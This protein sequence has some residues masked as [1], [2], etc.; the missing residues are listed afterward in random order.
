MILNT[1][2][3]CSSGSW[4]IEHL[5]PVTGESLPKA[6]C[7]NILPGHNAGN[8]PGFVWSLRGV[9]SYVRYVHRDER[10]QLTPLQ[11]PLG[12]PEA[13]RAALIPIKKSETWWDLP[14]D[15]RRKIFE[16]QSRH[17]AT[18]LKYLP[19]IARRLYQSRELGEPFDFLTWFEYAPADAAAFEDLVDALRRTKEW[20]YVTREIDIRLIRMPE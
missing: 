8:S 19:A 12:R 18:G 1:F 5:R 17:I 2:E 10:E 15:D 4:K 6:A 16:E 13:T 14:Q 3:G 20:T 9:T 7:L 11:P